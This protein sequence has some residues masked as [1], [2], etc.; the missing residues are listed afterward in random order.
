MSLRNTALK[1]IIHIDVFLLYLRLQTLTDKITR[2]RC[3]NFEPEMVRQSR[4]KFKFSRE[5]IAFQLATRA[6]RAKGKT[7]TVKVVEVEWM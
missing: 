4:N 3:H 5:T 6:V 7:R 2:T 1:K